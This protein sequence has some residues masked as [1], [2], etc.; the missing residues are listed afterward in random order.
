MGFLRFTSTLAQFTPKMHGT[1]RLSHKPPSH[2]PTPSKVSAEQSD[3]HQRNVALL[4]GTQAVLVSGSGNQHGVRRATEMDDT[5]C[6]YYCL[7]SP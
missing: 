6:G 3:A 7:V 4:K 5:I 2:R 1:E